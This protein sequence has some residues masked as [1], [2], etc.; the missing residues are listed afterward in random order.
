MAVVTP[1][2]LLRT[3]AGG[4]YDGEAITQLQ[5]ALQSGWWA[6][7]EGASEALQLAALFHDVGHLLAPDVGGA[8]SG[9]DTR[10]EGIGA[11]YLARW[12]GD[13]V[14]RPVA[15][16]VA[17]KRHLAR[18]AAYAA[19]LSP[20]STRSLALQG[21]PFTD[22]EDAAF[23]ADPHAQDALALRR[24]DDLAKDPDAVVPA[25][26]AWAPLAEALAR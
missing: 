13:D 12:Y 19:T 18:D 5:H 21:G 17:A 25:L 16:H 26:D 9:V 23:L 1:I 14:A 2:E 4:R 15:L 22:A 24:W 20:E 10:H 7:H 11:R 3:A 6:Q 8:A